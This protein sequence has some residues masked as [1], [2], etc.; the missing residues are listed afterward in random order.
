MLLGKV[1]L[2]AGKSLE[3]LY[4]AVDLARTAGAL[5]ELAWAQENLAVGLGVQGDIAGS[6]AVLAE[7]IPR[8]RE[9][10]L[11]QLAYLVAGRAICESYTNPAVEDIFTEAEELA[12]TDDLRLHTLSMRG[13]IALRHGRYDDTIAYLERC[14]DIMRTMPGIVPI[15]A[16]CWLV[17]G[18]SAVNRTTDAQ[19]A[20]NEA[21]AMPD[22]ARWHARP[23][24]LDAAAALL[25]HDEEGIDA[26]IA[27]ATGRMPLDIA[28]MQVIAADVLRGSAQHRWLR[29]AFATYEAAGATLMIERTRGML[30]AA[31]GPVPRRRRRSN[32]RV[33][34]QLAQRGVT[35]RE[36]EVLLLLRDGLSNADIAQRLFVSVRT[37]ETHVSSLLTKLEVPSRARLT[38]VTAEVSYET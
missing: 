36:A 23:V 18:L 37:I 17:W 20:L 3:R 15:D 9:L 28:L 1:D 24:I 16:P 31:G 22:L 33:P 19:R 34:E 8:C 21:R 10:R 4:E 30:R 27:G 38:A 11:D 29:D 2:F 7:A 32:A 25:A 14:V 12:P 6:A 35:A 13:D 26:A 5:V